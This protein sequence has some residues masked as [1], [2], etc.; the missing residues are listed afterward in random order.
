MKS[1]RDL[2][3]SLTGANGFPGPPGPVGLPGFNGGPGGPGLPGPNGFPG[4]P[5]SLGMH[6]PVTIGIYI[7]M[8]AI[9]NEF[10][11]TE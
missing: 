7:L 4:T 11:D 9:R 1:W 6:Q 10:L 2:C 3:L 5:G 8:S